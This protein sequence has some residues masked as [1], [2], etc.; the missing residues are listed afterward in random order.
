LKEKMTHL[1]FFNTTRFWGG[2]EKWHFETGCYLA[3]RGH[4]V[5]FVVHP[6]GEL[7]K[8]ITDKQIEALPI[9]VSNS[10]FLNP[11]KFRK[12]VSFYRSEQIQT[13]IFN[14]S[15][16]VK[17]G[18]LPAKMAGVPGIVY[19]RGLPVPV[20]NSL[21]NQ[22]LY[23]RLI[24]HFLT[25]SE[26]TAIQ[27]FRKLSVPHTAKVQTIYNGID[28]SRFKGHQNERPQNQKVVIGTAGRLET[29]KGHDQLIAAACRLKDNHLNFQIL[30]AGDGSQREILQDKIRSF[31]LAGLVQLL[32]FTPDIENFMRRLDI[33]VLPSKWEG[34]GYAS[35][36]AMATGLPVVAYDVSSNR[37]VIAIMLPVSWCRRKTS[38]DLQKRL[39]YWRKIRN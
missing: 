18:A 36:E 20:E 24:T 11:L 39:C 31:G 21:F 27:L 9:V 35:A 3:S 8:R 28:I 19:R 15:A 14:G 29:E 17:M 25:N 1:C 22:F 5:F 2:G 13:V 33:F 10:S 32:G 7:Y 12:L 34:F 16:D 30:I 37:E 38:K 4:R 23:G 6:G 26:E